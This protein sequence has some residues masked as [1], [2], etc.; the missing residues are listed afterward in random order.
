[1][2]RVGHRASAELEVKLKD[3]V[4]NVLGGIAVPAEIAFPE[5]LP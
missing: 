4:R 1:M 5:K 2:L 3:H